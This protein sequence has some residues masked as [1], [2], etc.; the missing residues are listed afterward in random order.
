MQKKA[1]A[2]SA[3]IYEAGEMFDQNA[4]SGCIAN[5]INLDINRPL[6]Q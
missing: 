5:Y 6:G 4:A 2:L 1:I 3:A